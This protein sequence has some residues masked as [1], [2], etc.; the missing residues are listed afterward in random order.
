MEDVYKRQVR[1]LA[2]VGQIA[3][4][5]DVAADGAGEIVNV[6]RHAVGGDGGAENGD[7]A[8]RGGRRL[9]RGGRVRQDVYKRQ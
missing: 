3:R 2:Q 1:L 4:A 8:R 6:Q 7:I 5:G 9:Q